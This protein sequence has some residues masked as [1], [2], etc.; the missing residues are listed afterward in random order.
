MNCL[1]FFKSKSKA[2][3]E[4]KFDCNAP[5]TPSLIKTGPTLLSESEIHAQNLNTSDYP[6]V[7]SSNYVSSTCSSLLS[8]Q[9]GRHV[10]R[11]SSF[12]ASDFSMT[13]D[14]GFDLS[15]LFKI[16]DEDIEII[17]DSSNSNNQSSY[18]ILSPN[19]VGPILKIKGPAQAETTE[20]ELDGSR[21][22]LFFE[23]ASAILEE[24]MRHKRTKQA[25]K[26]IQQENRNL[27]NENLFFAQKLGY[28]TPK[29]DAD[30]YNKLNLSA[31]QPS[32]SPKAQKLNKKL[33]FGEP[34]AKKLQM[35]TQKSKSRYH[36]SKSRNSS[37]YG[38]YIQISEVL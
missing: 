2:A 10:N 18:Q 37:G 30:R 15:V 25:L 33:E 31:N 26:L 9:T 6:S 12:H 35:V 7:Y 14:D 23:Q 16:V 19:S 24:K 34:A 29:P 27:L 21:G 28:V 20:S 13:P 5:V 8:N 17:D 36:S 38:S 22:D 3:K 1:P 11:L 4:F 32:K